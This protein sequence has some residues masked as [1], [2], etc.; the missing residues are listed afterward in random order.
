MTKKSDNI[1]PK[2]VDK[3]KI[4]VGSSQ[5]NSIPEEA[6]VQ[7]KTQASQ[8]KHEEQEM[9]KKAASKPINKEKKAEKPQE[10]AKK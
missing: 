7:P 10:K 4:K 6:K 8:G 3:K 1:A 5:P 9:K 2:V